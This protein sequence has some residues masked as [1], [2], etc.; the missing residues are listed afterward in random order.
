MCLTANLPKKDCDDGNYLP[1]EKFDTHASQALTCPEIERD[2][3]F[4]LSD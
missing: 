3:I 2:V 1:G 4:I